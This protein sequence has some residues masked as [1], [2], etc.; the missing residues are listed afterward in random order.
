MIRKGIV[1]SGGT[2]SR[3]YPATITTNKQL[4][5]IYDKPMIFYSIS[6]LMI[7]NIRDILIITNPNDK[8]YYFKLFGNGENFGIKIS[9]EIQN[10]PAGIPEA[11]KI[12]EKFI[13][14][15]NVALILG[16]NFIF[17]SDLENK[18]KEASKF[19]NG[20]VIFLTEVKNPERYGVAKIKK[21]KI[22]KIVEKPKTFVSNYAITG[23]YY[24][25]K[26]V[27]KYAKNLKVSK[28]NELEIVDILKKYKKN[29]K[30]RYKILDKEIVWLDSGDP[31]DL[32]A[33]SNFVYTFE[34]RQN[35]KIACL[36]EIAFKK[37]WITKKNILART[38]II[39]NSKYAEYL[40]KFL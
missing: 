33:A 8:V 31:D 20:S 23:L 5:P 36:E 4:L 39:K 35:Y 14:N 26:E 11:F 17:G 28:R 19:N 16:D 10:K 27:I 22:V 30:L 18:L 12:G 1:L 40:K 32:L 15:N 9:Y 6:T 13:N 24:F 3:L 37:K 38:K 25:D 21:S 7:S 34:K 29:K 2:G